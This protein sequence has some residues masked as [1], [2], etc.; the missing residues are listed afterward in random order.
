M[1]T[2]EKQFEIQRALFYL[3]DQKYAH[4]KEWKTTVRDLLQIEQKSLTNRI[5]GN[6]YLTLNEFWTLARHFNITLEDIDK[7]LNSGG[8]KVGDSSLCTAYQESI[9][10]YSQHNLSFIPLMN[11]EMK[12]LP[13]FVET[14]LAELKKLCDSPKSSLKLFFKDLPWFHIMEYEELTYFKMYIYYTHIVSVEM[15]FEK[16]VEALHKM[17]LTACF[18]QIIAVYETTPSQEIWDEGVLNNVLLTLEQYQVYGK[19]EQKESLQLLLDQLDSFIFRLETMMNRT[20]GIGAASIE[21]RRL[22]TMNTGNFM[23]STDAYGNQKLLQEFFM[24]QELGSA[25]P[26]LLV[27]FAKAFETSIEGSDKF[28]TSSNIVK[29]EFLNT[30]REKVA[31]CR[32]KILGSRS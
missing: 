24:L 5:S 28:A 30:L 3:I 15:S 13:L 11:P 23:L 21:A 26:N 20:D 4:K 14:I 32:I 9:C 19:F 25:H 16:F 29:G 7:R 1:A 22:N 12:E 17:N 2:I 10:P 31:A 18:S 6:V 27:L 8:E